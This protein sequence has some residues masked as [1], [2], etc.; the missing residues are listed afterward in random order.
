MDQNFLLKN[1]IIEPQI[2]N[3]EQTVNENN[4]TQININ[5]SNNYTEEESYI[6]LENIKNLPE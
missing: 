5:Q 1:H 4:Y 3:Y 2:E 6:K